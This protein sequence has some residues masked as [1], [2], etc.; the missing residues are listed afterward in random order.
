[1]RENNCGKLADWIYAAIKDP[2]YLTNTVDKAVL[3][4]HIHRRGLPQGACPKY[5]NAP[6]SHFIAGLLNHLDPIAK[7]TSQCDV[8]D[9]RFQGFDGRQ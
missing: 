2:T 1:M 4:K 3:I 8:R 7:I 5:F 9:A 6:S